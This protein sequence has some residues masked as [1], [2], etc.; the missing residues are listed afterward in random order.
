[1]SPEA[2]A[3]FAAAVTLAPAYRAPEIPGRASGTWLARH[4]L[5]RC[6]AI[7]GQIPRPFA[8]CLAL[9]VALNAGVAAQ[10]HFVGRAVQDLER[11]RAVVRLP[12]GALDASVAWRWVAILAAIAVARAIVQ[13]GAGLL[14]LWIGQELLSRLRL[15]ILVQVQRLDL[16]YHVRHGV[17]EIVTRTTRDA[18]KVR[19]ALISVWRNVVETI[20]VVAGGLALIAWY[21]PVLA[22]GPALAVALGLTWLLRHTEALVALDRAVGA[23][24]DA[25][26]Q[27]LAEGVHGV[28]VIKAFGLEPSR[29]RRFRDAIDRFVV[30][31]RSALRF[32]TTRVPVPQIIVAMGQVWVL[33]V[34]AVLVHRGR[35]DLGALVASLLMMN[36]I[37][38][39]AEPVGRVMQVFADAR[40]SAARIM[41]LVDAEPSITSGPARVPEGPLGVELR[42]A[43]VRSAGGDTNVLD[44]C[45]LRV[46]PGEVVAL[47]GATG[48]GK[49]TLTALLP[50][51]V[52]VDAGQVLL[53]TADGRRVD[54]RELDLQDL[55]RRVHVVP[56]EALLFS[57]TIAANLRLGA[58]DASDAEL[59]RA[60]HLAAADEIVAQLPDGLDT[61]VGD[62]GVTLSGGQRQRL[63]LARAFAARPAVLVL[64]DATSALDAIT[65]RRILDRL[66]AAAHADGQPITLLLVA[67]K[68]STVLLA[69]RSAVLA[70]GRIV[71]T[72][73]HE[74]LAR[75]NA[76]YRELLGI[77]GAAE[78]A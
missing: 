60:L 17:G 55:R 62:R 28:R 6:L 58:P 70:G 9:F 54:V 40:S 78:S 14:A 1:M 45:S 42:D 27:D 57:D 46:E 3:S 68:L 73:A 7:Y 38:F 50:R 25:V 2:P 69:D 16:A 53:V 21:A 30:L 4:P 66:R 23:A 35:I 51:L 72:G 61:V 24:F 77:A 5:I 65:E 29:I 18:D 64:D 33:I 74:A 48:S 56:Q 31:A 22:L 76:T 43:R 11:G 71:A 75:A 20:L 10:Q 36:T 52:D 26:N 12:G 59:A 37:V 13:Y 67:S 8:T 49:S 41:D 63:T 15:A 44:G 47:V 19:D 39:R 32:A 34:G